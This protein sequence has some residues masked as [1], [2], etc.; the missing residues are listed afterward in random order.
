MLIP[1]VNNKRPV[2]GC[3]L[4]GPG[5]FPNFEAPRLP[6]FHVLLDLED[7]LPTTVSNMNVYRPVLVT[8]K[9]ESVAVRSNILGMAQV[10]EC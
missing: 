3:K 8:V 1:L 6:E 2:L 4:F 9:K 5:Q 7:C 10:T